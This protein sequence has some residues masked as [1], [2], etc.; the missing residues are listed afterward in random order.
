MINK[1]Q[2]LPTSS[3][4]NDT[5]QHKMEDHTKGKRN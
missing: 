4:L 1:G 5:E 2:H 3:E